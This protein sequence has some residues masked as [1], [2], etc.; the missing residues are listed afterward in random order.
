[1][2]APDP[3]PSISFECFPPKSPATEALLEEALPHLIAL[4]PEFFT[5]TYGAGGTTKEGT[6]RLATRL[7]SASP[8]P[9]GAHLTYLTETVEALDAYT[10]RLWEE[11]VRHIVA[12]RGDV[13]KG[14]T[15]ADYA[16]EA[17][18]ACTADFVAHLRA[19]HP[20]EISVS[21]YPEKHPDAPSLDADLA[22]LREKEEAGADRAITQFFFDGEDYQRYLEKARA[23]GIGLPIAP[24]LLPVVDYAKMR[25]FAAAC[26]ATVPDWVSGRFER[27]PEEDHPRVARDLLIEQIEQLRGYGAPHFH[28]YSLNRHKLVEEA[29]EAT[30]LRVAA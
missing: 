9:V 1:M 11:G 4:A 5:V 25:K 12:L 19:R 3:L 2:N 18:F 30:G 10:D 13:P 26:E 24:G 14:R 22:T 7:A 16:D 20:F 21:A 29:L 27:A 28:F 6:F 23:A 17:A 8:I 15:L